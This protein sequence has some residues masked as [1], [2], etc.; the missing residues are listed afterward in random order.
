M[1]LPDCE[2]G[3][4]GCLPYPYERLIERWKALEAAP[5]PELQ[6]VPPAIQKL[7][8]DFLSGLIEQGADFLKGATI[9]RSMAE[10]ALARNLHVDGACPELYATLNRYE[11]GEGFL[12]GAGAQTPLALCELAAAVRQKGDAPIPCNDAVAV[13]KKAVS[14]NTPRGPGLRELADQVKPLKPYAYV[15]T[16][17]PEAETYFALARFIHLPRELLLVGAQMRDGVPRV[18]STVWL[19]SE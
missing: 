15:V 6:A 1:S 11:L 8:A 7:F 17:V 18:T 14:E 12:N 9:E 4:K 3:A 5:R 19:P 10:R 16:L 13:A 2:R